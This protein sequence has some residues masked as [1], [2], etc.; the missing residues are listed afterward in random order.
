[1]RP[2]TTSALLELPIC[3]THSDGFLVL[4]IKVQMRV[5]SS[6]FV[7]NFLVLLWSSLLVGSSSEGADK[8]RWRGEKRRRSQKGGKKKVGQRRWLKY[9]QVSFNVRDSRHDQMKFSVGSSVERGWSWFW[10]WCFGQEEDPILNLF[11]G[12]AGG[13]SDVARSPR[14]GTPRPW[15]IESFTSSSRTLPRW[16]SL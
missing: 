12:G 3:D 1:M 2:F 11:R 10:W 5:L 14:R 13:S 7:T 15:T 16:I 4:S 8:K 9:W 6:L